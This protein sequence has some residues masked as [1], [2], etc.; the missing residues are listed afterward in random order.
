LEAVP[1]IT[2]QAGRGAIGWWRRRVSIGAVLEAARRQAGLSITQVSQ[3]TRIRETIIGGIERDDFSA[4]G[5]D[6]Y[7]RGHIRAIARAVG[8]DGEP[9]VAE[10]DSGHGTP[11][12]GAAAGVPRLRGPVRLAE[13]RRPNWTVALLVVLAAAVGL[14][15]YH[16]VASHPAGTAA[17]AGRKHPAAEHHPARP[18]ARPSPPEVVIVLTA[19]SGPCWADLATP[20]G[21]PIFQGIL[22]PG[23]SKTWT[24]R[25]AVSLRLGNPGAVTLTVDGK[26]RAGLGTQPVTLSL[27]PGQGVPG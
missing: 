17:A 3:R 14:L 13:R 10:Y 25:Q 8:V 1:A 6:F 16:V 26:A 18:A 19:V 20:G 9:L 21:V 4:C 15:A 11:Q 22:Y 24:E 27:G 12:P 2:P 23:T 5:A 7:A